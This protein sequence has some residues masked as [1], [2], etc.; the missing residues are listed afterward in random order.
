MS[1]PSKS[2][3][4]MFSLFYKS[5]DILTV[6]LHRY[7]LHAVIEVIFFHL[8]VRGPVVQTLCIEKD[9]YMDPI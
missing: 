4:E 2:F 6:I 8:K 3:N 9:S 5:Y 7:I 1:S